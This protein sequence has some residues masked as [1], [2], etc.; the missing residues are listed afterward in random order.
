MKSASAIGP[1][2]SLALANAGAQKTSVILHAYL[3]AGQ[4]VR[5]CRYR[6]CAALR[7]RT[8]CQD[9]VPE[10]KPT[11]RFDDLAKLAISLH[12]LA[13]FGLSRFDATSRCEYFFHRHT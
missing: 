1:Q 10:R 8:N 11:A 12:K 13:I 4:K 2:R 7:A 6:F 9:Q 3:T 5:D